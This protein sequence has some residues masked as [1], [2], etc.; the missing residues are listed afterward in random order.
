MAFL[1]PRFA[2]VVTPIARDCVDVSRFPDK[3]VMMHR[4]GAEHPLSRSRL[5]ISSA[6]E[7]KKEERLGTG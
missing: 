5:V 2:L 7:K 1:S 6:I 4:T 3:L